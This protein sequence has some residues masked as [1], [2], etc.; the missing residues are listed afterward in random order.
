MT[1]TSESGEAAVEDQR[2]ILRSL[3]K[4]HPGQEAIMNHGA[5]FR[6][7]ACGRRW[8]KSEMAAHEAL[9]Y[10]LEHTDATVWWVAPTYEQANSYGFDKIKPLLSPDITADTPKLSKPREITLVTGSTLS[11]RSAEREDSL[12]GGGVDFLVI[13]EAGSVPDRAWLEEL[14]P[15]LSDTEGELLAIG[16]P[17]RRNWFHTWYN[18]GVDA[19][20]PD[21]ASWQ[22]PT[23]QNPHVPDEEVASARE[24]MPEREFRREYRAEFV[25]ETGS[26]FT[27]LEVRVLAEYD[28]ERVEG[29]APYTTGVDFARSDDYTAIVTLDANGQLVHFDRA[30]RQGWPQIQ[31]RVESAAEQYGGRVYLDATRDNKIV[32][33][34]EAAGVPVEP[35]SFGGGTQQQLIEDLV[36][37]VEQGGLTLPDMDPLV[38]ELQ[39]F[40]FETT[41]SGNVRYGAPAGFKDDCVDA[42]AL[43]VRGLSDGD[44]VAT[45]RAQFG[46][47]SSAS[48]GSSD[49][50]QT[51]G[52]VLPDP[53][54]GPFH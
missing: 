21:V 36:T 49:D 29:E 41:S 13:D 7:V 50:R 28:P 23:E 47:A 35:V 16:T 25:D 4:A 12:R 5:R 15:T 48:G 2:E 44:G 11:F 38:H 53:T 18:R 17:K 19:E 20:Y 52:D 45:A 22:A 10:A 46:E 9:E 40:E 30:R 32:A 8:G 27:D 54:R 24:D 31:R 26:V 42:L 14:R 39:V 34:L 51:W 1:R 37:T 33:D 3:W 6:L 43:A